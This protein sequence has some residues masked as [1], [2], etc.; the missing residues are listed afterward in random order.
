MK[1]V[2]KSNK[3]IDG[4]I[5]ASGSKNAALPIIAGALLTSEE[6]VLQNVPL[7][8]DVIQMIKLMNLI[9][10]Q[11]KY[12]EQNKKLT[13]TS[14]KLSKKNKFNDVINIRASYYI[15]TALIH[16]KKNFLFM[17]PRGCNFTDRPID[18]HLAIFREYKI[19]VE[20]K[21]G[22]LIQR[23]ELQPIN[24][25]FPKISVGGTINAIM[26][27]VLVKGITRLDNISI[28]PEVIDF[29]KYLNSMGA[30][31]SFVDKRKIEI[32]GVK[33]LHGTNYSIMS[34]RIE[35]GSYIL[36]SLSKPNSK[37]T[38]EK[39]KQDDIQ[40]ILN[41]VRELGGDYNIENEKIF[42]Q[43]PMIL[44][45]INLTIG[46]YPAFPTDLQPILSTLCLCATGESIIKDRVYPNRNTHLH[47]ISKAGGNVIESNDG[48][49][50]VPSKLNPTQ[51]LAHDL[52]CGF[53]M[54]IACL[55]TKGESSIDNFQILNR[56]YENIISKL[57]NIGIEC[58]K[59]ISE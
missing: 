18:I 59:I 35:I 44:Q 20:E 47:E 26:L 2:I 38:I 31:I 37:L 28:E 43:S 39:A 23:N 40:N 46:P 57:S 33:K 1:Y 48:V 3:D 49:K 13:I 36:L 4:I 32:T 14:K 8:T 12:D 22:I 7:I 6:V 21:D 15:M 17:Y 27:G 16:R 56:G 30:K 25:I 24:I 54:I 55:L 50:I 10:C 41:I 34:D 9:G 11:T 58:V 53:A 51:F 19:Q 45:P 42:V 29:I 5:E 52:R